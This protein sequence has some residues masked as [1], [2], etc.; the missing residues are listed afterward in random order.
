MVQLYYYLLLIET[1]L[2]IPT[3]ESVRFGFDP[4]LLHANN[5]WSMPTIIEPEIL[6]SF[7]HGS[8]TRNKREVKTNSS[9]TSGSQPLKTDKPPLSL[10]S[11][12]ASKNTPN[13]SQMTVVRNNVTVPEISNITTVVSV[14]RCH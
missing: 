8:A 1:V 2:I 3:Q 11:D 9:E 5:E 13:A 10:N 4:E 7:V 14:F 6:E 12:Q